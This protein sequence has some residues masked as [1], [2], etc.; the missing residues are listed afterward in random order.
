MTSG[1]DARQRAV[2]CQDCWF[3]KEMSCALANPVSGAC[4]NRRPVRGRSA[5]PVEAKQPQL[6]PLAD[7]H[8]VTPQP[9]APLPLQPAAVAPA[10]VP[11]SEGAPEASFS[12]TALTY[13]PSSDEPRTP[14]DLEQA[15]RS[16]P[17]SF[18]EIRAG[19]AVAAARAPIA[20]VRIP[21]EEIE[22][23]Q[24]RMQPLPGDGLDARVERVRRRTAER[25]A[26]TR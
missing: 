10:P 3:F 23:P 25:L 16:V 26:R 18:R 17:P 22:S 5:K 20:E 9:A 4:A 19:R 13:E 8:A 2:I 12:L 24:L 6:V 11:F 7:G 21:I 15:I 14:G 1:Q